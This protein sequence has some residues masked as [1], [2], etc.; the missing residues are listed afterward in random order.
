MINNKIKLI[1]NRINLHY[2]IDKLIAIGKINK[3]SRIPGYLKFLDNKN[4]PKLRDRIT[5]NILIEKTW[6]I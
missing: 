2:K 5:D 3:L 1:I 4:N 6:K